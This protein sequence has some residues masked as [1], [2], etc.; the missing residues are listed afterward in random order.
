MFTRKHLDELLALGECTR[1][2]WKRDF[3]RGLIGG[4]SGPD[5]QKG[6][7]DVLKD[8][9]AIANTSDGQNVGYLVYGVKDIGAEREV[10]GITGHPWDDAKFQNWAQNTFAPIPTFTY[11][12]I[13]WTSRQVIGVFEI[14]RKAE[15]PHVAF[16]NVGG[17][18]HDGQVW[19]RQGTMNCIAHYAE[20]KSM[21]FGEQPFRVLRA[22][23]PELLRVHEFY[24]QQ[25]FQVSYPRLGD[26]DPRLARGYSIAYY[27][28][29]RREILIGRPGD[30]L[31]GMM[32]SK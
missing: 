5:W 21:F 22:D 30:E 4:S 6:K 3:P 31:I 12:E 19:Y 32:R 13:T 27:P 17:V 14:Q 25:G 26:K 18:I 11:F 2:D 28:G 23:D 1:L 16:A 7:A 8:I 24:D 29:T 10:F 9:V 15:Y 20:L